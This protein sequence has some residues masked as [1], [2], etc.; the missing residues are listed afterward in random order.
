MYGPH[1]ETWVY[2]NPE[3]LTFIREPIA[4]DYID[5]D[6]VVLSDGPSPGTKVVTVAVAELYGTETGVGH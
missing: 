4:I 1:G 2:T 6:Q 5:G 3:P